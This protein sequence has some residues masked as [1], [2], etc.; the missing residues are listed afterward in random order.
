MPTARYAS[1]PSPVP[2]EGTHFTRRFHDSA[3]T[4]KGWSAELR[5]EFAHSAGRTRL[6]A[7]Q[8]H[9]PLVVQRPFYPEGEACHVYVVH[10]PGGVAG[11]DQLSLDMSVY[12]GAHALIT[13]PAATK[14]YKAGGQLASQVQRLTVRDGV[15][16][17]LPQENIFFGDAAVRLDTVVR[18]KGGAR[19]I[20]WEIACYGRPASRETLGHGK[21]LQSFELWKDDVPLLLDRLRVSGAGEMMGACWGLAGNAVL[22]TLLAYPFSEADLAALRE[23]A[24]VGQISCTVVDNVLVCRAAGRSTEEIKQTFVRFWQVLR[25]TLLNR[26]AVPPRIWAT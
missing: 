24:K 10:P 16:E 8:H 5:C 23:T 11:G 14:F 25:P 15:L 3:S 18:L 7:R 19:F 4:E 22:G 6:S 20:G 1:F 2:G 21:V 9:G 12:A 13:T 26:P 17:W